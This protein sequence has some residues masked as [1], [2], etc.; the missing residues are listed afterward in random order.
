MIKWI[1]WIGYGLWSIGTYGMSKAD[2]A[3]WALAAVIWIGW[4]GLILVTYILRGMYRT[5]T[6]KKGRQEGENRR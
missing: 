4:T 5:I 3:N 6:G 1:H 2:D